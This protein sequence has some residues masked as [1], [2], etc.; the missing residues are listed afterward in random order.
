[1]YML[2]LMVCE[3][4]LTASEADPRDQGLLSHHEEEVAHSVKIKRSKMLSSSRCAAPSTC[5]PSASSEKMNKLNQSLLSGS[6]SFNSYVIVFVMVYENSMLHLVFAGI[7]HSCFLWASQCLGL[8]LFCLNWCHFFICNFD[9]FICP[10]E[11][12]VSIQIWLKIWF[13]FK[14][15]TCLFD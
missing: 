6:H 14:P 4:N 10:C 3:T 9:Q 11:D 12:K 2:C 15:S 13:S 5:I 8:L 1:M 7:N